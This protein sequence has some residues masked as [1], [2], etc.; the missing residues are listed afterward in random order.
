MKRFIFRH[1]PKSHGKAAIRIISEILCH[2]P[3]NKKVLVLIEQDIK[4]LAKFEPGVYY[5]TTELPKNVNV[6]FSDVG[7]YFYR[8]RVLNKKK[9]IQ[10]FLLPRNPRF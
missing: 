5:V 3:N 2:I 10:T 9:R 8:F 1:D 7:H 6:I 4:T